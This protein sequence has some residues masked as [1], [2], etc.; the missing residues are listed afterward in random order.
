M[1][2]HTPGLSMLKSGRWV[3]PADTALAAAIAE[4]FMVAISKAG[5][6]L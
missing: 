5:G 3:F 1:E 4:A 2:N 6:I